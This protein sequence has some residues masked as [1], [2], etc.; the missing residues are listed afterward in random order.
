MIRVAGHDET[1][2]WFAGF[3][4]SHGIAIGIDF[5]VG[6]LSAGWPAWPPSW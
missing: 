4:P 1:V 5:A 3:R 2:Y 6:P